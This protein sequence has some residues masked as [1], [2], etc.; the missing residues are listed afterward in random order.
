MKKLTLTLALSLVASTAA[1]APSPVDQTNWKN[2]AKLAIREA[3]Q[4]DASQ[5]LFE[6]RG[7][8]PRYYLRDRVQHPMVSSE[9]RRMRLPAGAL[10]ELYL[11]KF[12][13]YP[14]ADASAYPEHIGAAERAQLRVAEKA[15]LRQG[16]MDAIAETNHPAAPFLLADV[17]ADRSETIA[18]RAVAAKALGATQGEKASVVLA[19]VANSDA[20]VALRAAAIAG[21]GEHRDAVA[22][23]TLVAL[24]K[25]AKL[26]AELRGPAITGLGAV[27][28]KHTRHLVGEATADRAALALVALF[29]TS[30]AETHGQALVEAVSRTGSRA[31]LNALKRVDSDLARRAT[32]RLMRRVY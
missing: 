24:A 23:D 15:A 16:L 32:Q 5:K 22:I 27:A 1:A 28:T 13:A 26:P 11:E 6:L 7:I 14:F 12:D 9:L 31:A 30:A 25:D 21:L 8:D 29:S 3:R 4:D 20:P 10:F 18:T 17:V 19:G 2:A